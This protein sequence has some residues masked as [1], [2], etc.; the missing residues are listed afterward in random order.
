[1]AAERPE[2]AE[3]RLVAEALQKAFGGPVAPAA[4]LA[5]REAVLAAAALSAE[6]AADDEELVGA[7][8]AGAFAVP[9]APEVTAEHMAAIR[10]AAQESNV[11]PLRRVGRQ[12][13]RHAVAAMV[14]VSTLA[15]GS[16][17]A[18]ASSDALPGEVLYP[19]KRAVEQVMLTAAWTPTAEARVQAQL[20]A[21]RLTEV[22][23]LLAGGAS[24]QS[25]APLLS[26]Y[27]QHVAAVE[28]LAVTSAAVEVAVLEEKADALRGQTT[29]VA[30]EDPAPGQ[31]ATVAEPSESTSPAATATEVPTSGASATTA[32][33][34]QDAPAPAPSSASTAKP[35]AESGT[36]SGGTSTGSSGGSGSTST[37]PSPTSETSPTP[38]PKPTPTPTPT[39][40]PQPAVEEPKNGAPGQQKPK[41][42]KPSPSPSAS[43]TVDPERA[44]VS[45]SEPVYDA[46]PLA[47]WEEDT[48]VDG[49]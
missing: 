48:F 38:S 9:L 11:V 14:A 18:A 43:P 26:E 12:V 41:P 28:D 23:L 46:G 22:E 31:S 15:G 40:S 42:N 17:V 47:E 37:Q 45:D 7:A 25:V 16:G 4:F 36:T 24:P 34:Q 6:E 5:G 8:M 1:M 33:D 32:D 27:D 44:P 10:A 21:R 19:V 30:V 20:A 49:S 39:D 2:N 13:G 3:E 29:T 35:A